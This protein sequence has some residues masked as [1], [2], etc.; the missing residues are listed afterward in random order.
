MRIVIAA[1]SILF[2]VFIIALALI[3]TEKIT[4]Q[5]W[6]HTP[7]YTYPETPVSAVIFLSAFAGFLF[8]GIVAV[9]EGSKTRLS[10]ARLRAHVRR[11]QQEIE[12]L[13]RPSMDFL[14]ASGPPV[15][16]SAFEDSGEVSIEEPGAEET[17][18]E[19]ERE[20]S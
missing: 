20:T 2:S 19:E 6:P 10:N 4:V 13:R 18:V 12:T 9:L 11:L 15:H 8:T 16:G 14:S 1:L 3:N 5:L 17:N 7:E